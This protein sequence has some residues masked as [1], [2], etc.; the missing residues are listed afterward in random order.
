M[1]ERGT[2]YFWSI[3]IICLGRNLPVTIRRPLLPS[4]AERGHARAR[5][6]PSGAR[7]WAAACPTPPATHPGPGRIMPEHQSQ[8][9]KAQWHG[10]IRPARN[11]RCN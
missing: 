1:T 5:G 2:H 7:P 11:A 9:A 8:H 6:A 10:V 4:G 3:G